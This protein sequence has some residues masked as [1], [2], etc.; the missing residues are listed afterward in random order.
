MG[1]IC[2]MKLGT[3][4]ELNISKMTSQSTDVIYRD[5][6]KLIKETV[7][8]VV[9]VCLSIYSPAWNNLAPTGLIFIKLGI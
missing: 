9:S 7:S 3:N 1:R 6:E 8:F 4:F 5:F 2:Y